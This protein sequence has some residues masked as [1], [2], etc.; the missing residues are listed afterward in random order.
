MLFAVA[1]HGLP[2]HR[3]KNCKSQALP[4]SRRLTQR[5]FIAPVRVNNVSSSVRSSLPTKTHRIHL[6]CNLAPSSEWF[7]S[8]HTPFSSGDLATK[9]TI[10]RSPMF[11]HSKIVYNPLH[12][13]EPSSPTSHVQVHFLSCISLRRLLEM[14]EAVPESSNLLVLHAPSS[15]SRG[16]PTVWC[17][18][19]ALGL[20]ADLTPNTERT[21]CGFVGLTLLFRRLIR[22]GWYIDLDLLKRF[23]DSHHGRPDELFAFSLDLAVLGSRLSSTVLPV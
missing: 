19:R 14:R 20:D 23:F 1:F 2:T 16:S 22:F 8:K 11:V 6:M 15:L 18:V 9:T 21:V 7:C 10:W 13:A 4:P 12:C 17:S 3:F 5:V